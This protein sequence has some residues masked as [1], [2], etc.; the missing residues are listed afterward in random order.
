M[1]SDFSYMERERQT[2]LKKRQNSDINEQ[3]SYTRQETAEARARLPQYSL[4]SGTHGIQ[5]LNDPNWHIIY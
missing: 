4:S 1:S 5:I 3:G 2:A